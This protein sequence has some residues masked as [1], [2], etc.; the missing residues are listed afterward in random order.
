MSWLFWWS[1]E[2]R[3]NQP[4]PLPGLPTWR[5][6]RRGRCYIQLPWKPH[7]GQSNGRWSW[8]TAQRRHHRCSQGNRLSFALLKRQQICNSVRNT[9]LYCPCEE[10]HLAAIRTEQ[11][12]KWYIH[13]CG[14]WS[15]QSLRY[16]ERRKE[17]NNNPK[18]TLSLFTV[19][20]VNIF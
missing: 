8:S 19:Q 7:L 10:N 1:S 4:W 5:W 13:H 20:L 15:H 11:N 16:F 18:Q 3:S 6:R 9:T 12:K 2:F 14:T 17:E